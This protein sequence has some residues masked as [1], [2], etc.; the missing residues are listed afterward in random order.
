MSDTN[1]VFPL[2]HDVLTLLSARLDT[3][4]IP[5][6]WTYCTRI[7]DRRAGCMA[8]TGLSARVQWSLDVCAWS[9]AVQYRVFLG[10]C[11]NIGGHY[12]RYKDK[13]DWRDGREK[14]ALIA[15]CRCKAIGL[16]KMLYITPKWLGTL[17]RCT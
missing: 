7:V 4:S 9:L 6:G 10:E 5:L 3:P 13:S 14:E 17:Q 15:V 12:I 16:P 1:L 11:W 8:A 2:V